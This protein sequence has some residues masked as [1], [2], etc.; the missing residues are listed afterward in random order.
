[1]IPIA[2]FPSLGQK[3]GFEPLCVSFSSFNLIKIEAELRE[4]PEL[5]DYLDDLGCSE[6][7]MFRD[8]CSTCVY[9]A[10]LDSNSHRAV[11]ALA[12]WVDER[13]GPSAS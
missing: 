13:L 7:E 2:R 12:L 1:V 9:L 5:G 6:V 4:K 10:P 8:R 11:S 3:F